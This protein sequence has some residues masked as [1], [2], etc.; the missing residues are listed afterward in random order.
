MK[1]G[2]GENKNEIS[3]ISQNSDFAVQ[4]V[5]ILIEKVQNLYVALEHEQKAR[6]SL[7]YQVESLS[8]R[9]QAVEK[10]ETPQIDAGFAND[11]KNCLDLMK[12]TKYE[13]EKDMESEEGQ[14]LKF[15]NDQ[16]K[17]LE[18]EQNVAQNRVFT[19]E[20]LEKEFG[21]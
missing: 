14:K 19:L 13:G 7:E 18:N 1:A 11:I 6:K 8:R 5:G 21:R 17:K 10:P 4:A 3:E 16:L 15:L 20:G 2:T 9:L 12:S